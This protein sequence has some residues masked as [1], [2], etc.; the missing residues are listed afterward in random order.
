[1]TRLGTLY[2]WLTDTIS[3]LCVLTFYAVFLLAAV[4]FS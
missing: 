4:V 2:E 3:G 1:M